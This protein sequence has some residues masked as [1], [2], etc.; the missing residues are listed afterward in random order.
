MVHLADESTSQPCV[1]AAGEILAVHDGGTTATTISALDGTSPVLSRMSVS[2]PGS[3]ELSAGSPA[4]TSPRMRAASVQSCAKQKARARLVARRRS[5][6]DSL[7]PLPPLPPPSPSKTAAKPT[8]QPPP[9]S[10]SGI[11]MMSSLEEE[12]IWDEEEASDEMRR[13]SRRFME[14]QTTMLGAHGSEAAI[15]EAECQAI[16]DELFKWRKA[17]KGDVAMQQ[18]LIPSRQQTVMAAM[19]VRSAALCLQSHGEAAEGAVNKEGRQQQRMLEEEAVLSTPEG[20]ELRKLR[21]E[22]EVAREMMSER[23]RRILTLEKERRGG[24]TPSP[25]PS[26]RGSPSPNGVTRATRLTDGDIGYKCVRCGY[27]ARLEE[28]GGRKTQSNRELDILKER[29]RETNKELSTYQFAHIEQ[30]KMIADLMKVLCVVCV[31]ACG[32]GS[33][34]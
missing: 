4:S 25:S 29:H 7:S 16:D 27:E 14:L 12:A 26:A 1:P 28:V 23:E 13:L 31:C 9:E 34:H 10:L 5:L 11:E 2:L 19:P 30:K 21:H 3:P 15:L 17:I 20:E 18:Q 33:F 32:F 22:L 8:L 6:E 24:R